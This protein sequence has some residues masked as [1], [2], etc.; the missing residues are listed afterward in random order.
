VTSKQNPL[1]QL[2]RAQV[3]AGSIAG[4]VALV[5]RPNRLEHHTVGFV[6]VE[7]SAFMAADSIFRIASITKPIIAAAA[8]LLVD[9]GRMAL[10]DPVRQW[11]PELAEPMVLRRPDGP[12]DDV[13]PAVRPITVRHLLDSRAGYGFPSDFSWPAVRLLLYLQP[14][15]RPDLLPAPETW[16]ARLAGIPLL[17]QPGEAWLYNTCYDILGVLIA[18]VAGCPLPQF[19]AERLFEPLGMLDTGFEVPADKRHRFTS[20]YRTDPDGGLRL[21]DPA[22]GWW[23]RPPAFPSGA[24]GL[25]STV[26][27]WFAF[28]AMLLDGGTYRG[29]R[30]LSPAAVR[31]LTT[32]QL[33]AEQRAAGRLFLEGQGWGFGG[34]V[35]VATVEPWNLPGRYGWV[36]GTG[37]TA[38]IVPATGR[39]AILLTQLEMSSPTPPQ[40]MREFWRYAA[41]A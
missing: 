30:L 33:T 20:Y 39:V 31:Q 9:D 26:E 14:G 4:A 13:V 41:T 23:S 40:L 7:Q 32:D 28:A 5:A 37:T 11:L 27:D 1:Q 34:S 10:A 8:M 24:G 29:R 21:V 25:V 36:G 18:R 2:L 17:Y 15:P 19:L 16:L 6:D 22:G 3:D 35:D 12:V 38:H